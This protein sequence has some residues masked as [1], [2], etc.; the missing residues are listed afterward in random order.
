MQSRKRS[1]HCLSTLKLDRLMMGELGDSQ[2]SVAR[3]HLQDCSACL[4][5]FES[6]EAERVACRSAL[7]EFASLQ[8]APVQCPPSAAERLRRWFRMPVLLPL[9]AVAILLL[10]WRPKDVMQ[11]DT[12]RT[13]GQASLGFYVKS[14]E[15]A[16]LGGPSEELHE[17][18]ALRFRYSA[19]DD[20]FLLILSL[21]GAKTISVYHS[22]GNSA[23]PISAGTDVLLP[24]SVMLDGVLGPEEIFGFFCE[25]VISVQQARDA[26]ARDSSNPTLAHCSVARLHWMKVAP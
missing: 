19:S 10:V 14:G 8:A 11:S 21:D 12:T 1:E 2:A 26:L 9:V 18:D 17:D 15:G 3:E 4:F 23:L 13:K 25:Q 22:E 6:L 7:P 5:A 24:G 16:R 20:A